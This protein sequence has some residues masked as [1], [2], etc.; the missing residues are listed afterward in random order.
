MRTTLFGTDGIRARVGN[1]PFTSEQL[2]KLG[3]AIAQWI[4]ATYPNNASIALAYDTRISCSLVKSALETGILLSPITII[5]LGILTTPVLA[6][7]VSQRNDI[8]SGIMI[9]ASHNPYFDN[10]IKIFDHEGKKISSHAEQQINFYFYKTTSSQTYRSLGTIQSYQ[11]AAKKYLQCLQARFTKNYLSGLT[12]A[13]DCAHGA[14]YR[15]APYIFSSLGA[16]IKKVNIQPNGYNI[17][18]QCGALFPEY[19]QKIIKKSNADIG[20]CFDGDGDRVIAVTKHGIIKNGDDF[21]YLL[22][23]HYRYKN[24]TIIVG[25]IMSNGRLEY[26]FNTQNKHII[27]TAVGDKHV[28][29]V[30]EKYNATL[31]G[32]PSGHIILNDFQSTGDGIVTALT[33]LEYILHTNNIAMETFTH[34]PQAFV[35]IPIKT[36]KNL[37][38]PPLNAI[39]E[40]YTQSLE[41]GRILVRY[42]G[43]EPILRIMVEHKNNNVA[44]SYAQHLAFNLKNALN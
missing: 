44:M 29:N 36:K 8:Y 19:L 13:L 32:E 10:G 20:F 18:K 3:K 15:L 16:R 33:I 34:W 30:L 9:S 6:Y 42:S 26:Y 28:F 14:S 43:T 24:N 17:N 12:I 23:N 31:G 4:V 37:K 27:R 5:D 40:E 7:F 21:L 35:N 25:T 11:Y 2:T 38:K 1:P 22:S 41:Q 39:I